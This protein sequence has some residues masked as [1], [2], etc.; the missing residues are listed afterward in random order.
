[1]RWVESA[2]WSVL[3]KS[4]LLSERDRLPTCSLIFVLLPQG[5]QPQQGRFRLEV[6][7]EPTQQVWFKEICLWREKPETWWQQY[8]GLMALYPLCDH[9]QPL[10]QAIT[11]AATA[12]RRRQLDSVQRADLLTTLGIFGRLKDR[13]LDVLSL[14]GREQMRDSPFYQQLVEE[15]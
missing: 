9:G 3:A 8:P 4:G 2:V 13:T 6:A 7:G 10:P 14:I 1:T 12:I 11:E 5:Y 15:G